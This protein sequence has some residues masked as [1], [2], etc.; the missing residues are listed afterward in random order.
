MG[1]DDGEDGL[2]DHGGPAPKKRKLDDSDDIA[3]GGV[4]ANGTSSATAA[5]NG[6]VEQE[7]EQLSPFYRLPPAIWM[8]IFAYVGLPAMGGLKAV[9]RKFNELLQKEYIW[10]RCRKIHC[11]D[12]PKPAFGMKEW[13]M[14]SLVR[15]RGC[16]KCSDF[17][18]ERRDEGNLKVYWQFKV[19][20][21]QGCFRRNV[22]KVSSS[23]FLSG[24]SV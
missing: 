11:P 6:Q 7:E 8:E 19:R 22:V 15:G 12:M 16:L 5:A 1:M 20:C 10:R 23:G 21:C 17:D 2:E 9:C 14:W 4:S 18:E 13:D 3:M 24:V